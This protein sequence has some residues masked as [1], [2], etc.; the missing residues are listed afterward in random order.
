VLRNKNDTKDRRHKVLQS[1]ERDAEDGED[2]AKWEEIVLGQLE[3]EGGPREEWA[4]GEGR[5]WG[6]DRRG[7]IQEPLRSRDMIKRYLMRDLERAR[8]FG[9]KIVEIAEKEKTLWREERGRRRAAKK[10]EKRERKDEGR[11]LDEIEE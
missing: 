6:K 8:D 11:G 1:L 10:A 3:R 4:M 7:W 2:E 9:E 5:D